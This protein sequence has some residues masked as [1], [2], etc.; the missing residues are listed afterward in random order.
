MIVQ[1]V[2]K[3]L[4]LYFIFLVIR[5]LLKGVSQVKTMKEAMDQQREQFT[6]SSSHKKAGPTQDTV[7][8]EFRRL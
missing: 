2:V 4:F 7:E 1:F 6:G 3:G 5:S 8:A